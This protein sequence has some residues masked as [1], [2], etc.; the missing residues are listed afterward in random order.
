MSAYIAVVD[1]GPV[2]NFIFKATMF[3][4]EWFW[5]IAPVIG[6]VLGAV[7]FRLVREWYKGK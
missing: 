1:M 6:I 5:M 2:G 4:A 7:I 3:L